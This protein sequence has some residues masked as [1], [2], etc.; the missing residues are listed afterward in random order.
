MPTLRFIDLFA[1][2]GGIRKG[3]ELAAQEHGFETKCVLTSEIKPAAL[4]I[5]H[6]NHPG[7][8]IHGDITKIGAAAIPDF[9]FLLAGFPCQ[10]FSSAGKRQGFLDTRGTMF[11]EVERI[12]KVKRPMGFILENVEGLVNHDM[13]KDYKKA[14]KPMGRT[15]ETILGKLA[16]LGYK[17]TW[18]VLNAS[19]FGVPQDRKRV[20][21]I[22][23]YEAQ[24][25]LEDFKPICSKL[26]DILSY[27]LQTEKGKFIKLLLKHYTPEQLKG[28]S[29]KD[30]RGGANN[31]HSWDIEIKGKVNAKQKKLL[32]DLFKE[33]RKKKWAAEFGIEW[34]D[35]MSLS[36][37]QIKTFSNIPDL[38]EQLNDLVEKGYIV[39]EHP[40][41]MVRE[42]LPDGRVRS[43]RQQDT[44]LPLGYNIVTGKLS[45]AV[46]KILDPKSIAP[47]LVAMDMNKLYVVD[48]AGLRKLTLREGLRLCGYP[49]D[50]HFDIPLKEGY[51][52]L[53]NTVVVPVIRAVA[54]RLLSTLKE[55]NRI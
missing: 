47:T 51:D 10:A 25:N 22:G 49:D 45:F 50:Y 1:G 2:I 20:Y 4:E 43:Y 32:N 26:E 54:D 31:I 11:F 40:K 29:L 33:R 53:G 36:L 14:K 55:N 24:P 8:T 7:E 16:E 19:E 27:G 28:K 5:L 30:K 17:V 41:K 15:L 37:E 46:S 34:M 6:Q 9:D 13:P 52:L 39:R 3:F 35:G 38:E 12:L 44:S 42:V 48:G 21:I 18:K 23:T